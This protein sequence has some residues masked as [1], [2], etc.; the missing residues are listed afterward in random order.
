MKW[1]GMQWNGMQCNEVVLIST[2]SE[3]SEDSVQNLAYLQSFY[4]EPKN[5]KGLRIEGL[6]N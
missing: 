3:R 2:S 1:N 4:Q 6:K 5:T